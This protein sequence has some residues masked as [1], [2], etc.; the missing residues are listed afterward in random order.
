MDIIKNDEKGQRGPTKM[1]KKQ[2][3]SK[4]TPMYRLG[5]I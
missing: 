3:Y 4:K 1:P 2:A 5:M